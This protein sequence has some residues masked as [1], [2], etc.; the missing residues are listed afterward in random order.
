MKISKLTNNIF[1]ILI[2]IFVFDRAKRSKIKARWTKKHLSRY[3]EVPPSVPVEKTVDVEGGFEGDPALQDKPVVQQL[4]P[5]QMSTCVAPLPQKAREARAEDDMEAQNKLVV[6]QLSSDQMSTCVAPLWQYWHQGK[7]N[8]P[9]LIQKCFESVQK[10]ENDK[11]IVVLSF[12]TVKDYVD[13]PQKYYDLVNSKKI[14]IA[15]F[16]DIVRLY[17]LEKYGGLWIDST[18]LLTD[19]IP[20]EVWNSDFCVFQKDQQTDPQENRMSCYFIRAKK[21]SP[22][23]S[24]IKK[25]IENYWENNDFLINYF[26]FEHI[27][28]MLSEKPELK[29]EWEKMPYLSAEKAGMLQRIMYNSFCKAEWEN[30]KKECGIHKLT[31]KKNKMNE[32]SYYDYIC[33]GEI[34][35]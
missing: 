11:K 24:A 9:E 19:K 18:I 31:Y 33:K 1:K 29:S 16:S 10:F 25:S 3:L 14:P 4:S 8:A 2:E 17:L 32:N 34:W 6:S 23:L 28:T 12:D 15:I 7:E 5:D 13:V 21:G 20:Q 35:V 22:N 30:L 27:S 26:M